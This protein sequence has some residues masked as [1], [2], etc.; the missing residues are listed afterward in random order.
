MERIHCSYHKCLT[1][2][3]SRVMH[4]VF[5]LGGYGHFESREANFRRE[6]RKYRLTSLNNYA[7]DFE[8]LGENDRVTRFIRDPRDLVVSGYFYHKRG[9]EAWC[10][11]RDPKP[12]NLRAVN[13]CVPNALKHGESIAECLQRLDLEDGLMAEIDFRAN[14]FASMLEWPENDHRVSVY[15]YEEILG[16]ERIV[17]SQ[18][19]DHLRLGPIRKWLAG[20]LAEK[21]SARKQSQKTEHIRNPE[22]AQWKKH[23]TPRVEDYLNASH[24][25]LLVRSGYS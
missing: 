9:A 11:I 6:H 22:S 25:G 24:P 5:P 23:F 19:A 15:R 12:E 13:G 17:M 10:T 18:L 7:L 16:N 1:V 21:Y 14:H 20:R 3:F 8:N 2:F 4:G